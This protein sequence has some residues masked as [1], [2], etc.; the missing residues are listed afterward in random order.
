MT[1]QCTWYDP[2]ELLPGN[3]RTIAMVYDTTDG[4]VIRS[5]YWDNDNQW[6]TASDGSNYGPPAYWCEVPKIGSEA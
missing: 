1:M 5:G 2:G 6:W 3:T 4:P